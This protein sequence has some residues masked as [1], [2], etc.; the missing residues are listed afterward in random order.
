MKPQSGPDTT[1]LLLIAGLVVL[2]LLL[3][4]R[5]YPPVAFMAFAIGVTAGFFLLGGKLFGALGLGQWGKDTT[6]SESEFSARVRSRLQ[7][8]RS[9]EERFRDE[10]ERILHSIATLK[11][12]LARNPQADAAGTARAE[13]LIQEL[14]AEFSL[15]HAKASFFADCAEQ[16]TDLL[17][18]HRLVESMAARQRELRE[19]RQTNFDDEAAVEETRFSIEQDGIELD[20]I[21]ELSNSA[22]H[23]DKA[24]QTRDLRD[25]LEQLRSQLSNRNPA[26][27]ESPS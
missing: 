5:I 7:D 2:S 11:D 18:R 6:S 26:T 21:V 13:K 19:L 25:R 1:R 10:G 20:T 16:L 27:G 22:V 24:S 4:L 12:D 17:A 14:E 8:C 9:R 23:T 15:R 3:M